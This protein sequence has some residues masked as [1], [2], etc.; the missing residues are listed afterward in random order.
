MPFKVKKKPN[1][2]KLLSISRMRFQHQLFF[3]SLKKENISS[4]IEVKYFIGLQRRFKFSEIL[5]QKQLAY[6]KKGMIKLT[7][8]FF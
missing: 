4:E 3:E 7:I 6:Q 1:I 5:N 2:S 8:P